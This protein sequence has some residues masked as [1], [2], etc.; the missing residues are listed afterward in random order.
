MRLRLRAAT[1]HFIILS[2]TEIKS[3][4]HL[5]SMVTSVVTGIKDVCYQCLVR[6]ADSEAILLSDLQESFIQMKYH[7]SNF[8]GSLLLPR[9]WVMLLLGKAFGSVSVQVSGCHRP[10]CSQ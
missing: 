1:S 3:I 9:V 8:L 10:T 4:H 7:H 5:V 2:R 6:K